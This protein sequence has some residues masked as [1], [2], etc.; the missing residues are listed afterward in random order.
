MISLIY[1]Q[2]DCFE[3]FRCITNP[4]LFVDVWKDE[5]YREIKWSI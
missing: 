5:E 4:K 1:M 3:D 2:E